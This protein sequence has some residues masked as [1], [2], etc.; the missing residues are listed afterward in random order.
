MNRQNEMYAYVYETMEQL[1]TKIKK[2]EY[3]VKH[4]EK[5]QDKVPQ[6]ECERLRKRIA[7]WKK[8][9]K[10]L[11]EKLEEQHRVIEKSKEAIA[12]LK[13][14]ERGKSQELI[15][16][17]ENL[18]NAIK[19]RKEVGIKNNVVAGRAKINVSKNQHER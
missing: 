6:E 17:W 18:E 4:P 11:Y 2:A 14:T 3:I 15:G 13:E 12:V 19:L 9:Y 8:P 5:Y 1:A 7:S 16:T 10:N